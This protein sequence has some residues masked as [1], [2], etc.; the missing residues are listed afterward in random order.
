[1]WASEAISY[2]KIISCPST[3]ISMLRGG[4][5]NSNRSSPRLLQFLFL[6]RC[7]PAYDGSL[8]L[9]VQVRVTLCKSDVQNQRQSHLAAVSSYDE[10]TKV[11]FFVGPLVFH[12]LTVKI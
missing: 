6:D 2:Q 1:M 8:E 5:K 7:H 11:L 12:A 3:V 10:S 9:R 4:S